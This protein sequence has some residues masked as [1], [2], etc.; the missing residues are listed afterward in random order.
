MLTLDLELLSRLKIFSQ[1][2]LPP[3]YNTSMK[4][5]RTIS[6]Q[7]SEMNSHSVGCVR[8]LLKLQITDTPTSTPSPSAPVINL[9]ELPPYFRTYS[10]TSTQRPRVLSFSGFQS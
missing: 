5:L 6:R 4:D 1:S 10:D 3:S 2:G 7:C 8:E 9:E